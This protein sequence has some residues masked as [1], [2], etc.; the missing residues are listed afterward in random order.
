MTKSLG[1]TWLC[2]LCLQHSGYVTHAKLTNTLFLTYT[3]LMHVSMMHAS[4]IC[5]AWIYDASSVLLIAQLIFNSIQGVG[6]FVQRLYEKL[7]LFNFFRHAFSNVSSNCLLEMMQN[8]TGC[9]CWTFHLCES[10]NAPSKHLPWVMHNC[11]SCICSSFPQCASLN[12]CSHGL[13]GR[14]HGHNIGTYRTFSH[15][16]LPSAPSNGFF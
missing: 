14:I 12:V 2:L 1:A 10:W 3:S 16:V 8:H 13:S 11:T 15:Y 7:Q 9:I 5:D 4:I 6:Y